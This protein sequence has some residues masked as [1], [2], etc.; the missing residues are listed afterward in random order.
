MSDRKR[1]KSTSDNFDE[2]FRELSEEFSRLDELFEML[3]EK[4]YE[5]LRKFSDESERFR[6]VRPEDFEE[7]QRK[8]LRPY[9]YGFRMYIGP[10]GKIK[11]DEFGNVRREGPKP[12]IAEEIEP[13]VDVIDE[14][15]KVRIIAEIPGVE[16]DKIELKAVGKEL[17]IQASNGKK[18]YKKVQLPDEVDVKTAKAQYRNGV[19]EVE[20]K[21]IKKESQYQKE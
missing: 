8:G 14:G 13:L 5:D 12:K 1:R 7:L 9:V 10:D 17:I 6:R 16:K 4:I 18:Y 21:K 19:L 11:I 2:F 15:D 3:Y 20:L